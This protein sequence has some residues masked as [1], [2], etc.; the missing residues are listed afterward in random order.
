MAER[1]LPAT[2]NS[3]APGSAT[4]SV[5]RMRIL[6]WMQ[7]DGSSIPN[8]MVN[9]VLHGERKLHIP[10]L[11]IPSMCVT[12][13]TIASAHNDRQHYNSWVGSTGW[14]RTGKS[15]WMLSNFSRWLTI[16]GTT[17]KSCPRSP[18]R[19][20][21]HSGL[22]R[23]EPILMTQ[24]SHFDSDSRRVTGE[25]MYVEAGLTMPNRWA[26]GFLTPTV[27]YRSVS[28]ELDDHTLIEDDS[29]KKLAH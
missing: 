21:G 7:I 19:W 10:E 24:L 23:V 9:S 20:R 28:Y 5:I 27:K 25:R 26:F 16:F 8:T 13:R 12:L 14:V 4:T 1:R 2:G 29:L 6:K 11:A 18:P 3:M 15:A 17:I 22:E